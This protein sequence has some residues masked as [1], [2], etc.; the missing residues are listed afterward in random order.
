[1]VPIA[2]LRV[3][4]FRTVALTQLAFFEQVRKQGTIGIA[5]EERRQL[6]CKPMLQVTLIADITILR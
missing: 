5:T 2:P 3:T 4:V 1:M 6:S